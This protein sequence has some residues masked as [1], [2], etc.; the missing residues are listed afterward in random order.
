MK[1]RKKIYYYTFS[2]YGHIDHTQ[3]PKPY[4]MGHGS[5]NFGRELHEH[6]NHALIFDTDHKK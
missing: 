6:Y 2:L 1:V 5:H 4:F 3:G